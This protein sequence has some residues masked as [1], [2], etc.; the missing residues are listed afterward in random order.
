[1][2]I[3]SCVSCGKRIS[4]KSKACPHCGYHFTDDIDPDTLSELARRRLRD[5]LYRFRMISYLCLTVFT[6][7]VIWYLVDTGWGT[8]LGGNVAMIIMAIG[9]LAYAVV[10][11]FMIMAKREYRRQQE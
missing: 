8:G 2:S 4:S 7:G 3:V 5:K 10:R 6:V 11:V 1:M 9:G